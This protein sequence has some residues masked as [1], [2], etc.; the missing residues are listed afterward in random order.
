MRRKNKNI[1]VILIIL[2]L[3]GI[4]VGY[5]AISRALII[6]GNSE[7]RQNTWDI[8]FENVQV[9]VGSVIAD[10]EPTIDNTNLS[11]D[12]NFI[13]NL[14]GDFY[15]FTVDV[16]NKGT[17]DAMIESI[18]KTPTLTVDQEK[19]MNYII[20]YQNGEQIISNHLVKANEFV[21]LKI[22]VEFKS[23]IEA[24]VPIKNENLNLG[25]ILN[26]VQSDN[27]GFSVKD[28]GLIK[29]IANGSLDDIG[30]V[31]T[32]GS[33]QFY[34]FGTEG[35][36]VK[37]LSMYNLYVGGVSNGE[38]WDTYG[39]EA[40][41][42]Q[43]S[44]GVVWT[45]YGDEAHG[46]QDSNMRAYVAMSLPRRGT[47][48]FSND[49]QKGENYSSYEGSIV[50]GYVNK[51][52][53]LL[54]RKFSVVIEEAR[55]ITYEE[56][57]NEETFGC[58][59]RNYCS[60][61]FPWLYTTSYYSQSSKNSNRVWNIYSYGHFSDYDYNYTGGFGVRPVIVISKSLF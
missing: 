33:E 25:F 21:R 39:D 26:Y 46:M 18:I 50:E 40:Y 2:V 9:T 48:A 54:E 4:S 11:V 37:L 43:D 52:K 32:I 44:N 34:I 58:V 35:D 27:N 23:N 22:R 5:A 13:L 57:T 31:V 59:E 29:P 24:N 49:E 53:E 6:T 47:T 51:Y 60:T 30:T 3:F 28:N 7:V 36:N 55:L 10:K 56:L 8:H 38:T 1:Y 19:Y 42:T 20:E 12:F 45:K 15:E 16:V 41:G 14:P 17:L 61:R